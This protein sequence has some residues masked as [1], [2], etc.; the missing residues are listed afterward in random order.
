MSS[1]KHVFILIGICFGF[2]GWSSNSDSFLEDDIKTDSTSQNLKS[3]IIEKENNNGFASGRNRVVD[4]NEP[5]Q[6]SRPPFNCQSCLSIIF[7]FHLGGDALMLYG[8]ATKHPSLFML[9]ATNFFI[10]MVLFPMVLVVER[11]G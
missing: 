10:T 7:L 4:E 9:G 11:Y 1:L 3:I 5:A 6:E 2:Q 8:Y